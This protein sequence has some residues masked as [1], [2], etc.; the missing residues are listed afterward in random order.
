MENKRKPTGVEH[1]KTSIY[2]VPPPASQ[3]AEELVIGTCL[4]F[5]RAIA[6]ALQYLS[7]EHFYYD[8]NQRIFKT[9]QWMELKGIVIDIT[10]VG[11]QLRTNGELDHIPEGLYYITQITNSIMADTHLARHCLMV[12]EKYILRQFAILGHEIHRKAMSQ[13]EDFYDIAKYI[14]RRREEIWVH[15]EKV[16]KQVYSDIVFNRVNEILSNDGTKPA[17]VVTGFD[18]IDKIIVALRGQMVVI[19]AR[20]SMGKTAF[21]VQLMENIEKQVPIGAIELESTTSA[22]VDRH[23]ANVSGLNASDLKRGG[24]DDEQKERLSTAFSKISGKKIHVLFDPMQDHH[25]LGR[26]ITLWVEQYG[27]KVILIDYLQIMQVTSEEERLSRERQ[28]TKQSQY[29]AALAAKL[30]IVVFA[31]AQLSREVLKRADKRPNLGD[32]R[33]SGGIEQAARQVWFIHRP[34]YYIEPGKALEDEWGNDLRGVTEIIIAKNNEGDTGLA[35][36]RFDKY[37][38]KFTDMGY[39]LWAGEQQ[40]TA[41]KIIPISGSSQ[42]W[43]PIPPEGTTTSENWDGEDAPF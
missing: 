43:R 35:R 40:A 22:Y 7:S 39:D 8:K 25:E 5:P 36:L 33:E 41:S 18:S 17:G 11:E 23:L 16:N 20:P 3:A 2:N 13:E 38:S 6:T 4:L 42:G 27:V 1:L 26:Q 9:M 28:V 12:L 30:D 10:T 19:A 31:F 15:F 37:R 21:M 32:L 34:E 14:T 24:L 29:I